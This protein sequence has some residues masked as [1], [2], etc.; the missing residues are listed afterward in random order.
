M[1]L[2]T[3]NFRGYSDAYTDKIMARNGKYKAIVTRVDIP[4]ATE[5]G[6]GQELGE[7]VTVVVA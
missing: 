6:I 3:L 2:E 5:A 1:G 4:S 7:S